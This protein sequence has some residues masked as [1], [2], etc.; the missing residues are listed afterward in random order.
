MWLAFLF[1]VAMYFG[2]L[3]TF[4]ELCF[5]LA[6]FFSFLS[7]SCAADGVAYKHFYFPCCFIRQ[8]KAG[9]IPFAMLHQYTYLVECLN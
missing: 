6:V 9:N 8:T 2:I 7:P 4:V 3:R 1:D 5:L